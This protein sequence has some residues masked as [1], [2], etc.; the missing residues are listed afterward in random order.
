MAGPLWDAVVPHV[1]RN[2]SSQVRP[3]LGDRWHASGAEPSALELPRSRGHLISWA[4]PRTRGGTA[5]SRA[6]LSATVGRGR[7]EERS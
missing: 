5:P 7:T 4:A 3:L 2:D 6:R 1:P